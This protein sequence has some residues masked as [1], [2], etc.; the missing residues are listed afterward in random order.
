MQNPARRVSLSLAA[1]LALACAGSSSPEPEAVAQPDPIPASVIAAVDA[2]DRSPEDRA[3]DVGRHP[4]D[5]LAFYGIRPGMRVAELGAGSG[6]TSELL[7]RGVGP[8]GKVY[9][10]NSPFIL[11]R[12]AQVPWTA[13]LSKPVMQNV[14][15]LDRP[16]DDPFPADVRDLDAVL[17]VL[18]YHDTVWMKADRAKMNRAVF[19][20]LAP[21]GVYGVVD[22]SAKPGSGLAD[23]ET[24]HRIDEANVRA[25]VEAAGFTLASEGSFLRNPDDPRDW[26]AS[27]RVAGAQRGTSDRFA[28]KFVKPDSRQP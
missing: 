26:N 6:Y 17:I 14:V 21:G 15:R 5:L 4:A 13:R 23:V 24:V 2:P 11:E 9:A 1:L 28:L 10:Q 22:H 7:A 19:E 25:E 20:A 16:F 18:L 12:F 27:P 8:T 3:L